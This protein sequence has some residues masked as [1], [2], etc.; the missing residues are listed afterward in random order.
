[1]IEDALRSHPA[2]I[3]AGAVGSPDERAGEVPVA[4]VT[5]RDADVTMAELIEWAAERVS[6]AAASPKAVFVVD[7]LPVTAVGKPY[8]PELRLLAAREALRSQLETRGAA[9][10][11]DAWCQDDGGVIRLAIPEPSDGEIRDTI[12][13]LLERYP[14]RWDFVASP[15]TETD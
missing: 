2:V 5:V 11:G 8:K 10:V 4:F 9:L 3:D 14:F 1:V 13:G 6:E 12:A 7:A 15:D